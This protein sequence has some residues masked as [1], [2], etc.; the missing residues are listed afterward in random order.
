LIVGVPAT[1]QPA[2]FGQ[3]AGR[4][5]AFVERGKE[6]VERSASGVGRSGVRRARVRASGRLDNDGA[7]G[8]GQHGA[9]QAKPAQ[10]VGKELFHRRKGEKGKVLKLA[11]KAAL[12]NL[13]SIT[14][15]LRQ[16][17]TERTRNDA[18]GFI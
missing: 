6:V 1:G 14:A 18:L 15:R 5:L 8:L 3:K 13:N 10:Q 11:I 7:G 2:V 12:R 16:C 9:G 4:H 17:E